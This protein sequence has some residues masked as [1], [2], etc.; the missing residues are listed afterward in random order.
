MTLITMLVITLLFI[1]LCGV[2]ATLG[3]TA[4]AWAFSMMSVVM[5]GASMLRYL[6]GGPR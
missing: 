2:C 4:M 3:V 1:L 5:L 6:N